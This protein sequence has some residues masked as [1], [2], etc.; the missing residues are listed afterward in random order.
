M[1]P[2]KNIDF[3]LDMILNNDL[4]LSISALRGLTTLRGENKQLFVHYW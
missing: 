4:R 3:I 1:S 2:F